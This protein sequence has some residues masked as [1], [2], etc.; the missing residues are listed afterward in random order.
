[1]PDYLAAMIPAVS[2]VDSWPADESVVLLDTTA[3]RRGMGLWGFRRAGREHFARLAFLSP[4]RI[5]LLSDDRAVM[6]ILIDNT[7]GDGLEL[8]GEAVWAGRNFR[9]GK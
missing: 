5:V 9:N 3:P 1:M 7:S 2:M 8:G 4:T 6:P